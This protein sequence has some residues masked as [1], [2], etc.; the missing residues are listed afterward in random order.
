MILIGIGFI[1][2]ENKNLDI[3]GLM[4]G[5]SGSESNSRIAT[6]PKSY[7]DATG[8]H[9]LSIAAPISQIAVGGNT[10]LF[11]NDAGSIVIAGQDN[12]SVV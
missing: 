7:S 12:G 1:F 5:G 4:N 8:N 11:G 6:R 10:G 3:F 2:T 9:P